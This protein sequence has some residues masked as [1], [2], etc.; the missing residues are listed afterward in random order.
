MTLKP[1]IF[2]ASV[3]AVS[4][5]LHATT[6]RHITAETA[7]PY[8]ATIDADENLIE[9]G[10]TYACIYKPVPQES[11]VRTPWISPSQ[12]YLGSHSTG[13]EIDAQGVT[14]P[15]DVDKVQHRISSGNDSFALTWG[16]KRYTGFA[17]KLPRSC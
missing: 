6:Y 2:L 9:S 15:G 1:Y 12:A 10:V 7:T 17:L 8:S 14:S 13:M 5:L 4:S 11:W 3:L 16:V